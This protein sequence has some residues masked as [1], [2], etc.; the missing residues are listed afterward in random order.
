MKAMV[1]NKESLTVEFK[2]DRGPLSDRELIET[3]VCL[4]NSD[5][6]VIYL[7]VEDDG[8]VTGVHNNHKNFHGLSAMISNRTTPPVQVSVASLKAKNQRSV[9]RIEVPRMTQLIA[10]SDGVIK[11]RRIQQDGTPECIPFPPHEFGSRLATFRKIDLSAQPVSEATLDDLDPV[12]RAR[13]RQFIDRNGGD[14]ALL[15]LDDGR[16]DGALGLTIREGDLW[17]PTLTG[18]LLIGREESLRRLVP[19]HEIAFQMLEGEE[20]R[21]NEFTR[22][23]L[24]HA[25][26]WL[27]TLFKPLNPESE[28][29]LGL[30]RVFVPRLDWRAFREAL[31]NAVIHRDYSKIG[32]VHVRIEG[33]MLTISNPGGLIEGVTLDNLL[34][35]E[36]RPRNPSLADACKRIGLVERTGRGVDIIYRGLL[37]YGKTRPDYSRTDR[38][39][40]ILRLSLSEANLAFL[41]LVLKE[42]DRFGKPLPIDTLI[43]L[44]VLR[45]QKRV[46]RSELATFLQKSSVDAGRTL[47]ALVEAGFVQPHGATRGRTYTLSPQIYKE[48]GEKAEYARQAGF[49]R[50]QQE[51]LVRNYVEQNGSIRRSDVM[52]LCRLDKN[53][54]YRLLKHMVASNT[55]ERIG[56]GRWSRYIRGPQF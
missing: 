28:M 19:T 22:A 45:E 18:L 29:Q 6:G 39:N 46:N 3:V 15:E 40:V 37:R 43:T 14:A 55:L 49:D 8:Q 7:G 48:L 34:T 30:F 27:E 54:A 33:D 51:Q 44:S 32:A 24:I 1:P 56:K 47:E 25:L 42:E 13:L 38:H 36:P 26:E 23:P 12:Q 50:L 10:T 11:R 53:Q 16:F 52:I 4:A 21:L 41:K 9:L 20:V 31:A 5:G 2:S 17:R 35:T